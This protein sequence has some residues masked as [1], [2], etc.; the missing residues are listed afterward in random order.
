M[1][2]HLDHIVRGALEEDLSNKDITSAAIFGNSGGLKEGH[3]LANQNLVLSGLD[4]ARATFHAVSGQIKV[5]SFFKNGSYVQKG[6]CIAKVKGMIS[7]LLAAERVALNFLQ[8]LSGISTQT[9][10]FVE[11]VKPYRCQILDT[12]K[13]I[14]GL[15]LLEKKAVVHGGG[16]NHRMNLADHYLIKDNHIAAC[17][18]ISEA[19][20]RVKNVGAG[21]KPARNLIEVEAKSL[22]EVTEA[23]AEG[24]DIILLD[25]MPLNE[26]KKAMAIIADKCLAEVSGGVNLKNVRKIAET[27]VSRISIGAL[28]HSAP[29][30]DISMEIG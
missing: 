30:V 15:R 29:A 21:L 23:V 16:H 11:R 20:R 27:G 25:N 13:T 22:K 10:L 12:R 26:I 14:P 28:T 18:G 17:G 2:K 9:S 3:I 19:I 6:K 4:E 8:H 24:V 5:M 7:N 1:D